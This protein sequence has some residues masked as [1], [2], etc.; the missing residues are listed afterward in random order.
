M[1]TLISPIVAIS[2]WTK[3]TLITAAVCI[4]AAIIVKMLRK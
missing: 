1:M 4:I 2:L 3:I